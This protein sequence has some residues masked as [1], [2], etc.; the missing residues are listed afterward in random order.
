MKI[1]AV[2]PDS[3]KAFIK[4]SVAYK[5]PVHL[6]RNFRNIDRDGIRK[7]EESL[8]KNYFSQK[9]FLVDEF[10]ESYLNTDEGKKDLQDHLFLRLDKNRKTVIPWLDNTKSLKGASILEIGCGTGASTVALSE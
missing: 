3:I 6:S 1:S 10:S 7:I 5:I 9:Q 2:L 4:Q 8:K